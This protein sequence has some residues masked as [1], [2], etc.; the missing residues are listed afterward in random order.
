[1]KPSFTPTL[2]GVLLLALLGSCQDSEIK[3]DPQ[4]LNSFKMNLNA[5]TW[6]PSV[7]DPCEQTYWAAMS[8]LGDS[9]FYEIKAYRDP[10]FVANLT[11]ENYFELKVMNVN[12]P[13]TYVLDG[14]FRILAT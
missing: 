2:V 3:K 11:S 6:E 8:L 14:T 4:S 9:K 5:Q 13:G 7:I 12:S 10:A 1:M